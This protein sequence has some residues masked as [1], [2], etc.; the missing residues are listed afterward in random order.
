MPPSTVPAA[1]PPAAL[2]IGRLA[3][4]AIGALL[5]WELRSILLLG[6][7]SVLIAVTLRAISDPLARRTRVPAGLALAVVILL[8]LMFVWPTSRRW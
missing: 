2:D 7:T 8:T 5:V 6:F 4:M 1:R 3:L